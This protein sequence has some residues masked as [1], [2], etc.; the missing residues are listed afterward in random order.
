MQQTSAT[1]VQDKRWLGREDDPLGTMQKIN[2]WPYYLM[3]YLEIRIH[4][5]EWDTHI[6]LGF[7]DTNRSHNPGQKSRPVDKYQ[8]IYWI[9]DIAPPAN[10]NEKIKENANR[11]R[12]LDVAREMIKRWNMKL[13]VIGVHGMILKGLQWWLDE[14]E[15]GGRAETIQITA[16]LWS[17]RILKRVLKT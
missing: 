7:R 11:D 10:Q 4:P 8:E 3:V 6:F 13:T 16:L 14:L 9:E 17:A 1:T 5:G 12:Y 15:I 2:I